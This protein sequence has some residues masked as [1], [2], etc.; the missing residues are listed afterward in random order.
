LAEAS[1]PKASPESGKWLSRNVLGIGLTSLLSD[2]SHEMTT[3][4][5]PM[6]LVTVGGSAA[7]LGLIEGVADASSSFLKLWMSWYTDRVG[8]RKPILVLGYVLTGIKGLFAFTTA[9]WQVLVIRTL[10]WMGRGSR[11]PAR[12]ALL[13]DSVSPKAYGRAFGFHRASD[14]MGAILG[15]AI[16]LALLGRLGYRQIFLVSFVPGVLAVLAVLFLVKDI[17]GRLSLKS[18]MGASVA[19]LPERFKWYVASVG[20]FGLG[21]FA[22][23]LLTLRAMR[24]LTPAMGASRATA[25]A[26][27]LYTLHNIVYAGASYPVGMLG[28]RWSKRGLLL[29]GYLLFAVMCVGFAL[30]GA[31]V[32]GLGFL[33]VLAGAYVALVDAMEGALAADLLPTELRGTGYGVLGMV[34]GVGDLVSSVVVGYLL[35]VSVHLSFGYGAV[36]TALGAIALWRTR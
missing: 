22:H 7:L 4:I 5:L 12:D 6:F 33:F 32:L 14:T 25:A 2:M 27:L 23:S 31:S 26:V 19:A 11:G 1:L 30:V 20:V 15:P 17:P 18:R 28:D 21:N 24:L 35:T 29:T 3:A 36:L 9:W 10:A 34:N 8:R 16:A 13:A